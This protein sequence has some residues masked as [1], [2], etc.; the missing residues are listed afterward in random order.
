MG[1]LSSSRQVQVMPFE[2]V[3]VSM[4]AGVC[5]ADPSNHCSRSTM[6]VPVL[7]RNTSHD[8]QMGAAACV[9]GRL[10]RSAMFQKYYAVRYAARGSTHTPAPPG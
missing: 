8:T 6:L 7:H 2:Q 10:A 3:Q 4:T 5:A 9:A 1:E